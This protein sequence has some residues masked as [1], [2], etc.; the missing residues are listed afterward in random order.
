MNGKP[1]LQAI[2]A[3]DK[4]WANIKIFIAAEYAKENKQNKISAK[5]FKANAMQ[6]QAEATEEPLANLTKAHTR[7]METLVKTTT[8]AIKEMMLQLKDNKTPTN[9]AA[10]EEKKKKRE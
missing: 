2:P 5:H 7:Q 3:A 4:T 6:E 9:K 8:E 10:D 1:N